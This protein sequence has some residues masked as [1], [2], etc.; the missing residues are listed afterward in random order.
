MYFDSSS[1]RLL[2]TKE[3]FLFFHFSCLLFNHWALTANEMCFF[4]F[5]FFSN[6]VL[7]MRRVNDR[8]WRKVFWL[9]GWKRREN[10]QTIVRIRHICQKRRTLTSFTFFFLLP[11][12]CYWWT[13]KGIFFKCTFNV[14][15]FI[16]FFNFLIPKQYNIFLTIF[17]T[18]FFLPSESVEKHSKALKLDVEIYVCFCF[19]FSF[20]FV[21]FFLMRSV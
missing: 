7:C 1:R 11:L 21:L 6:A 16:F 8:K 12:N 18:H 5:F 2:N 3:V 14:S 13:N 15:T 17:S 19:A 10:A 4:L 20:V 9:N